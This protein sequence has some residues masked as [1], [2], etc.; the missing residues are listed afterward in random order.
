MAAKTPNKNQN[1]APILL[2]HLQIIININWFEFNLVLNYPLWED[3]QSIT[4]RILGANSS[5]W[6]Q[7]KERVED[8]KLN[9]KETSKRN[10][11]GG[12]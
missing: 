4:C 10:K 2:R 9:N 5:T 12:K 7:T 8:I 6:N 3:Y 1:P 11:N